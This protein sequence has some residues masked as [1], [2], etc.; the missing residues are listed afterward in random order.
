MNLM[1][2]I[3]VTG[4][5]GF[6]G[7]QVVK[8]L[9]KLQVITDSHNSEHINLQNRDEVMELESA[10]LVIHLGGK[11]PKKELGWEEYFMNNVIGTLN[12][13]EY[14]IQKK[15]KKL[16]YVSSYVYGNPK[17]CPIDEGHPVNP[18]NAYTESK[19]LGERL[20]EFYCN[21]TDLNLIILRP[22]NIFGESLRDGFMI[23]NLINSVKTGKKLIITNKDSKR[24][25]LYVD[26]FVDLI[27][28]IKDYDCKFE[29]FNV[30]TGISFSFDQIT[31]KIEYIT[32]KKLNIE[33][34]EDEKT[35]MGDIQA[36][37]S[38]LKDKLNWKPKIEF[39]EGLRK[40]LKR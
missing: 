15:I 5:S 35:F 23:T 21:G 28:K 31:K 16:I 29:I 33:Y 25:F 3:L 1:E 6:I 24:D 34:E 38:K 11:T 36:D 8:R 39:E 19:Y 18:H 32:S 40:M 37:I 9:H 26:D 13:L 22:F 7:T 17:Y 10:D 12:V 27:L 14:C 30:G 2:K 20:C 4:S